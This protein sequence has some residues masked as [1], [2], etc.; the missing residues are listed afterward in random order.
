MKG[1][2][3]AEIIGILPVPVKT[4]S[5]IDFGEN[6]NVFSRVCAAREYFYKKFNIKSDQLKIIKCEYER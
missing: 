2:V 3:T 6:S 5:T 1:R 4:T